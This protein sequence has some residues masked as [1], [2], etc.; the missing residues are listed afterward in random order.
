[1][2][3]LLELY[4]HVDPGGRRVHHGDTGLHPGGDHTAVQLHA[5]GGQLHP[6]VHALDQHRVVGGQ[7]AHRPAVGTGQGHHIGEV[8]LAL[9]VVPV[10]PAERP[11]Q[12]AGVHHVHRGVDLGQGE[13]SVGGVLLLHDLGDLAVG[14]AHHPAVPAGV[15]EV[16]GEHGDGVAVGL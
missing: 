1:G 12:H 2:D 5:E 7:C 15:G 3:V 14:A 4:V 13:L 8:H 9:G 11:A 6:V 10:Q 16:G